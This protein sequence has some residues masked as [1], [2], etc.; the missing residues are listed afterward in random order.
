MADD[1]D[2]KQCF[3][4]VRELAERRNE[5]VEACWA[6][7][8][9]RRLT[10]AFATLDR[11]KSSIEQGDKKAMLEFILVAADS[12]RWFE[13]LPSDTRKV[14]A[15]CLESMATKLSH[16]REFAPREPENTERNDV[17]LRYQ[18]IKDL[19]RMLGEALQ[20]NEA[21]LREVQSWNFRNTKPR[22]IAILLKLRESGFWG[23]RNLVRDNVAKRKRQA[24]RERKF[25]TSFQ[26]AWLR[27]TKVIT[28]KDARA[29]LTVAL[30]VTDTTIIDRWKDDSKDAESRV[31]EVLAI[32]KNYGIAPSLP[33]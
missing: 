30:G 27:H 21:I 2:T 26:L 3:D 15:D 32:L 13:Q 19:T 7:L 12:F 24:Q 25:L 9:K 16:S 1:S 29:Q 4:L 23:C 6:E 5:E 17:L 33:E 31:A 28:L 18:D 14:L 20:E 11:V 8:E 10:E 22:K